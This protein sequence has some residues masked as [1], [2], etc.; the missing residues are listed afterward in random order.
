M[1]TGGSGLPA[2]AGAA[3]GVSFLPL[4]DAGQPYVIGAAAAA[5]FIL[6]YTEHPADSLELRDRLGRTGA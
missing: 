2:G 1:A 5:A 6:P 3:G 4:P